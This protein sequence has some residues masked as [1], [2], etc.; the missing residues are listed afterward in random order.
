VARRVLGERIPPPPAIVPELPKDEKAMGE[1]TLREAL[2]EH[3]TREGCAEC[4]ARFDSLGLVFEA[5]GP[6]GERRD[7]DLGGRPVDTRA[8]FPN[9]SKGTGLAGLVEYVRSEREDDFLDNLTRKLLAYGLGR[10]LILSDEPLVEEMRKK[11]NRDQYRFSSLVES[12]VTSEQFLNKRDGKA[13]AR[14]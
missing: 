11:L 13:L 8:D 12:I 14:N 2:E 3:R 5:Y 7:L 4:H 9:G 10:T 1:R 6:V